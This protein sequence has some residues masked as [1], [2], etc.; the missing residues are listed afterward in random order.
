VL[1]LIVRGFKGTVPYLQYFRDVVEGH[2][3]HVS[4]KA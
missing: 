3:P 1:A 4:P 2:S